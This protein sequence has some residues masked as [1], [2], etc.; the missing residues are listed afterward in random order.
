LSSRPRITQLLDEASRGEP[1]AVNDLVRQ[2]YGEVHRLA[3]AELSR[4]SADRA[5]VML[6]PTALANAALLELVQQQRQST[7]SGQFFALALRIVRQRLKDA[8]RARRAAK[9]GGQMSRL[10][11]D[12]AEDARP[13][14]DPAR[15]VEEADLFESTLAALER[16]EAINPRR[17]EVF[18]L[19]SVS[20]MTYPQIASVLGVSVATVER[21]F[22]MARAWLESGLIKPE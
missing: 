17:A 7:S 1:E 9:R 5:D 4:S 18:V 13:T 16:L 14:P 6:Q 12:Q 20:E 2:A 10:E 15:L 22:V 11:L 19:R 3:R 21:D 8:A